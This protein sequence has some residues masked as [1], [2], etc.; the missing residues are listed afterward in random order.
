MKASCC[1]LRAEISCLDIRV[2][3][4]GILLGST[5]LVTRQLWS[6]AGLEGRTASHQKPAEGPPPM[7]GRRI[8]EKLAFG[9]ITPRCLIY[10]ALEGRDFAFIKLSWL[11]IYTYHVHLSYCLFYG[12]LWICLPLL[13]DRQQLV[14]KKLVSFLC[15]KTN[16]VCCTE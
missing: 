3:M 7:E 4:E 14:G 5:W 12:N 9:Q 2:L 16:T 1:P 11:L 15:T 10:Y 6:R 8:P 13:M